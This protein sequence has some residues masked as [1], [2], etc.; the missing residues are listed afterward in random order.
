MFPPSPPTPPHPRPA[1]SVLF[2]AHL[3]GMVARTRLP[4][5]HSP[6]AGDGELG[7]ARSTS[8]NDCGIGQSEGEADRVEHDHGV[9]HLKSAT[10]CPSG[11]G[12]RCS[13]PHESPC[14]RSMRSE[15]G[16][17]IARL[18]VPCEI[19]ALRATVIAAVTSCAAVS[20]AI[21]SRTPAKRGNVTAVTIARIAS[22][23]MS[24]AR[25]RPRRMGRNKGSGDCPSGIQTMRRKAIKRENC[26][27]T[28][29]AR[30]RYVLSRPHVAMRHSPCPRV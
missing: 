15:S 25:V 29:R 7:D 28:E 30:K 27:L 24:S 4:P 23:T 17:I 19:A 9:R 10:P 14:Q 1:G 6:E 26:G 8:Q 21:Q 16:A 2:D 22:T 20:T 18:R 13:S 12:Q 5:L 3:P 11:P